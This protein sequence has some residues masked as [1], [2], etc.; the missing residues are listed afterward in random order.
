MSSARENIKVTAIIS[1]YNSDQYI[2]GCISDLTEQTLFKQGALELLFL[3]CDSPGTEYE[4]IKAAQRAHPNIVYIRWPTRVTLYEAWNIGVRYARGEF[5]T[6]ANTDDRH[7][8]DSIERHLKELSKNQDINIVYADVFESTQPNQPFSEN[9]RTTRY[10]YKPFFAPDVMLHYQFGCQPLWRRRAHE[11]LGYFNPAL[12]AAGDYEFNFR[13][14]LAG[15]QAL[16]IAEPLGSFLHRAD[17]ISTQ[18]K[19]SGNEAT[20]LRARFIT[21]ENVL[22]LYQHAGWE[23]NS[24]TGKIRAFHDL[25]LKSF[26]IELPWHPGQTFMDAQ[27]AFTCLTAGLQISGENPALANNLAVLL[28]AIGKTDDAR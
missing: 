17:S 23:V 18:D 27:V 10:C 21:A 2:A 6:N 12:R 3:D 7:C 22:K 28:N 20:E 11:K 19:T 14:N 15:L 16:H 25:A 9:P 24:V 8:A 5:L 4:V 13:F 26:S 1:V